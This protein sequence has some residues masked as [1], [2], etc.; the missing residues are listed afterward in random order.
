MSGDQ[1]TKDKEVW[2]IGCRVCG[3]RGPIPS[4]LQEVLDRCLGENKVLR[5]NIAAMVKV[6]RALRVRVNTWELEDLCDEALTRSK[7]GM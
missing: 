2:M 6:L 3:Q 1:S 7:D 4:D 5:E